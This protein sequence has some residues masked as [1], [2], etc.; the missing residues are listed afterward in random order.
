METS[1]IMLVFAISAVLAFSYQG[2]E[3][4]FV[5]D[6]IIDKSPGG[7]DCE[8]HTIGNWNNVT[9]TCALTGDLPTGENISINGGGITLDGAGHSLTGTDSCIFTGISVDFEEDVLIKNVIV[10]DFW[11]GIELSN[12]EDSSV[13]NSVTNNN[14]AIGIHLTGFS[15]SSVHENQSS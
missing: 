14:C 4:S 12:T 6:H 7:G 15:F 2:A 5:A 8:G 13:L 3:A 9:N 11:V 10:K 1:K